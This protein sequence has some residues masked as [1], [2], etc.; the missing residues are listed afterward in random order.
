MHPDPV[1]ETSVSAGNQCQWIRTDLA[2]LYPATKFDY[3]DPDP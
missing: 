3:T 1:T 2:R